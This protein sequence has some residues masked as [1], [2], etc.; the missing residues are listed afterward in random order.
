MGARASRHRQ[1]PPDDG[2]A[3][4]RGGRDARPWAVLSLFVSGV[5]LLAGAGTAAGETGAEQVLGVLWVLGGLGGVAGWAAALRGSRRWSRLVYLMALGFPLGTLWAAV[6]HGLRWGC[7]D[8]GRG[9]AT[10]APRPEDPAYTFGVSF[11]GPRLRGVAWLIALVA[12]AACS[13]A[14]AGNWSAAAGC[15]AVVPAAAPAVVIWGLVPFSGF[16]CAVGEGGLRT[17]GGEV[18]WGEVTGVTTM[19]VPG[20]PF[21]WV[22]TGGLRP[23]VRIPLYLADLGGFVRAVR[24][25]A[26]ADHPLR[27]A[28]ARLSRSGRAT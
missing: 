15:L 1:A 6:S 4:R 11:W 16:R 18:G 25:Y 17:G 9:G 7:L 19:P 22:W 26:P 13:L 3:A 24:K 8:P 23:S 12:V 10:P 28:L 20:F 27:G 2:P 21:L 14:V 5:V